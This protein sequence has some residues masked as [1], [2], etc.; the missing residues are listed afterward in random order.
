M[1]YQSLNGYC[2]PRQQFPEQNHIAQ[3]SIDKFV[4]RQTSTIFLRLY[5]R[6]VPAL[7]FALFMII[8]HTTCQFH[9]RMKTLFLAIQHNI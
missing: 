2:L 8:Y 6:P 5:H 1:Q 9:H 4:R 3:L 7:R